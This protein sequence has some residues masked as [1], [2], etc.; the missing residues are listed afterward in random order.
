MHRRCAALRLQGLCLRSVACAV[1]R[2]KGGDE[3]GRVLRE[4]GR[5]DADHDAGVGIALIARVLAHAIGDHAPRLAGSGHYGAAGAHAKTVNTAPIA[6]VVHQ[7]V[8]GRAQG[9]VACVSAPAR[10]VN[11]A[12]RM[13]DTKPDRKRLG[14]HG[15]AALVE[16]G[17]GIAGAVA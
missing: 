14:L 10:P 15:H 11:H 8:I 4:V 2:A 9:R 1:L 5:L 12:L 7:F 3:A 13:L 6:G 17:K 16:H